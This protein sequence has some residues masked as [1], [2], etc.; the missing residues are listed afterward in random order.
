M[1]LAIIIDICMRSRNAT[2][3]EKPYYRS[4]LSQTA[5]GGTSHEAPVY[6]VP[7]VLTLVL[8]TDAKV[9]L[10]ATLFYY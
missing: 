6:A 4:I 9:T 3:K 1:L 2:D 10:Q 8:E 7:D 5:M